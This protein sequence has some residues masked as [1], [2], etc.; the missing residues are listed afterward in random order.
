MTHRPCGFLDI[1]LYR[2]AALTL[3][4][5]PCVFRDTDLYRAAA[6]TLISRL[7]VFLNTDL[8]R[9]VA[10]TLISRLCVFLDTDLYRAIALTLTSRPCVFRDTDLHRAV[11]LTPLSLTIQPLAPPSCKITPNTNTITFEEIHDCHTTLSR[12]PTTMPL[13][14]EDLVTTTRTIPSRLTQQTLPFVSPHPVIEHLPT[15]FT[16]QCLVAFT[17]C[18]PTFDPTALTEMRSRNTTPSNPCRRPHSPIHGLP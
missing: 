16:H 17:F 6:L 14:T 12:S 11:A 2:A 7:C 8:Y 10:L 5:R 3:I 15:R 9:A 13:G 1:R 18:I 4:S